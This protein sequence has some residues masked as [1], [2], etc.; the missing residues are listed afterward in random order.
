M[1]T[2]SGLD[3][4]ARYAK[5]P[6]L[7]GAFAPLT[8]LLYVAVAATVA[9]FAADALVQTRV[10]TLTRV[11]L[12]QESPDPTAVVASVR[13]GTQ[14]S[15]AAYVSLVG[16]GLITMIWLFLAC[17]SDRTPEFSWRTAWIFLSWVT[18]VFNYVVPY[19]LFS[20]AHASSQR[21]LGR[22][23]AQTLGIFG[24]LWWGTW[25]GLLLVTSGAAL[26]GGQ[27]FDPGTTTYYLQALSIS[28]RRLLQDGFAAVSGLCFLVVIAKLS[29]SVRTPTPTD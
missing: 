17:R 20:Q 26:R 10:G 8:L 18:P 4:A 6:A 29:R 27:S 13:V 23:R 9:L 22:F 1:S 24:A 5:R 16:A 21:R 19:L 28:H 14:L 3:L 12:G 15:V 11:A 7:S 2:S 25:V